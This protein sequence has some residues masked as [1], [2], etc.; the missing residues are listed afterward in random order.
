[1][2]A[3]TQSLSQTSITKPIGNSPNNSQPSQAQRGGGGRGRGRGG[4]RGGNRGGYN[5]NNVSLSSP[6]PLSLSG[7]SRRN[8]LCCVSCLDALVW[9]R[10]E[11]QGGG[12]GGYNSN[13]RGGGDRYKNYQASQ[14][15]SSKPSIDYGPNAPISAVAPVSGQVL[16]GGASAAAAPAA[17][18]LPAAAASA[19]SASALASATASSS[20]AKSAAPAKIE[21]PSDMKAFKQENL[22]DLDKRIKTEVCARPALALALS[23]LPSFLHSL[24][25]TR[26]AFDLPLVSCLVRRLTGCD[27][28][29]EERG[30]G[31]SALETCTAQRYLPDG[32]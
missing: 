8:C 2:E 12:R 16:P 11:W 9:L 28:Q 31:G 10:D 17:S 26:F 30:V 5:N 18:A 7:S 20:D 25:R 3:L 32:L 23:L 29:K 27:L 4:N 15:D 13:R 19:A 6:L 21:T 14:P 22:P 24:V 1:M